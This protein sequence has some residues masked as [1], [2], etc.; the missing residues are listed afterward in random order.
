MKDRKCTFTYSQEIEGNYKDFS[1]TGFT[2]SD[3]M[4]KV[5]SKGEYIVI[6]CEDESTGQLHEVFANTI[7]FV[8]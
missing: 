4:R 3:P 6:L 8:K 5:T 2:R 1:A 7:K